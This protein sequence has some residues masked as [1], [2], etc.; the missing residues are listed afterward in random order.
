MPHPLSRNSLDDPR[1]WR[2]ADRSPQIAQAKVIA[3]TAVALAA[4]MA[5][6]AVAAVR[7]AAA[8][9]VRARVARAATVGAGNTS[10]GKVLVDGRGHT[11]YVFTRDSKDK[12]RCA[13]I[14]GCSG[15][16]QAL[17]TTGRP[18]ASGGVR[19]SLL[20]TIALGGRRQVTYA[21]HPLYTYAFDNAPDEVD[22]VGVTQF[23]GTWLALSTAGRTVG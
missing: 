16:W 20:G 10:L 19:A 9:P 5:I 17:T 14:S 23:G 22:Y 11:L 18:H 4:A 1:A 2:D 21:G 3:A 13:A 8:Q 6:S 15:V 7:S 12:D